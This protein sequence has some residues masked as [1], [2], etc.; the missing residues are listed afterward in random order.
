[1]RIYNRALTDAEIQSLAF[2]HNPTKSLFIP[3][4]TAYGTPQ[5]G[6]K[7]IIVRSSQV[8][9]HSK[10]AET[11]PTDGLVFH[12]P[13]SEESSTAET[14][15]ALSSSGTITYQTY[16]GIQCA[17]FSYADISSQFSDYVTPYPMTFA[18]WAAPDAT[19]SRA[20]WSF[21]NDKPLMYW[22]G[23]NGSY[24]VYSPDCKVSTANAGDWHHIAWSINSD[25]SSTYYFD[26]V[27]MGTTTSDNTSTIKSLWIGYR[28]S[29]QPQ[30]IGYLAGFRIYNRAL[31][32][33]EIK[34]LAGEYKLEEVKKMFIAV[35][36][37]EIADIPQDGLIF[38][39]PFNGN[40]TPNVGT[41]VLV[42]NEGDI[43]YNT[44]D[45]ITYAVLPGTF[46]WRIYTQGT[47]DL[48]VGN[49]YSYICYYRDDSDHSKPSV[50]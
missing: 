37:T 47:T 22:N 23:R 13:L 27:A 5:A 20:L 25:L 50:F 1:M 39:A 10:S 40:T 2:E 8:V 11:M 34:T 21:E 33:A 30:W 31:S 26:G 35:K 3:L 44:Q 32:D 4:K 14:G 15:Q 42:G 18:I 19:D 12:A 9:G 6:Q 45:G 29:Y 16:K 41:M 28:N 43:A 17:H 48:T 7:G 36:G 46:G 38:H 49:E 24:H